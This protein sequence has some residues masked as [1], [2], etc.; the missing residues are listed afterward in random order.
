MFLC[1]ASAQKDSNENIDLT[2]SMFQNQLQEPVRVKKFEIELVSSI[3]RKEN[4]IT[5][6]EPDNLLLFRLGPIDAGE[7]YT[8]ELQSGVYTLADLAI[9]IARALN[10]AT[11]CNAWRGWSCSVDGTN[12]FTITFTTVSTPGLDTIAEITEVRLLHNGFENNYKFDI[13]NDSISLEAKY[14]TIGEGNE[15][16][17]TTENL[18]DLLGSN[19]DNLSF[20]SFAGLDTGFENPE[21]YTNTAIKEVGL[22]EAGGRVEYILSPVPVFQTSGVYGPSTVA[23]DVYLT[24]ESDVDGTQYDP[25]VFEESF[26]KDVMMF[27]YTSTAGVVSKHSQKNGILINPAPNANANLTGPPYTRGKFTINFPPSDVA[28]VFDDRRQELYKNTFGGN[29]IFDKNTTTQPIDARAF[30]IEIGGSPAEVAKSTLHFQDELEAEKLKFRLST[31]PLVIGLQVKDDETLNSSNILQDGPLPEVKGTSISYIPGTIGRMN[32]RSFGLPAFV[33]SKQGELIDLGTGETHYKTP[34]YRIEAVD[35]NGIPT[36]VV[37][38]DGGEHI[39]LTAD[40]AGGELFLNDPATF[41]TSGGTATNEEVVTNLCSFLDIGDSKMLGNQGLIEEVQTAFQYLPTEVGIVNDQVFQAIQNGINDNY[42]NSVPFPVQYSKDV[43]VKVVPLTRTNDSHV[44]FSV[45]QFQPEE[46]TFG[47]EGSISSTFRNSGDE[48]DFK[49]LLVKGRPKTWNSLSYTSGSAPT[50]WTAAFAAPDKDQRIKIS[51][52]QKQIYQQVI[53]CSFSTDAGA[54]F[55]EE[56]TLL[57]TSNKIA[58]NKKFEFTTKPRLFP[59]HPCISQYP[60]LLNNV[61]PE[62]ETTEIKG[63]FTTYPRSASYRQGERV[64]MGTDGNYAKN[65]VFQTADATQPSIFT[66][67]TSLGNNHRPQIVLKTK[68]TG[69]TEVS[70]ASAY[71]LSDGEIRQQEVPPIRATLGAV[72][73]L[74]SAYSAEE[75]FTSPKNFVGA[76]STSVLANIPTV[77]VEIN[78]I[79]IDGYIAKDFDVRDSQTGV[80]SRLPIVGVIPSLEDETVS[81]KPKIDFRYNAPYSQPVRCNLPTEQ[82]LYNLSFR[83]REI[84]TGRIVEGLR[85]P[86]ELIFR[87]NPLEENEEKENNM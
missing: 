65:L 50:N 67:P 24:L 54:S 15:A 84:A 80:G 40:P 16:I 6:T 4:K 79:P 49:Q 74:H 26:V 12:K 43:S 14:D 66:F 19:N 1:V 35:I 76:S 72:I 53:K 86:T 2:A 59:M 58:G 29:M 39:A 87:I 51:I 81:T 31:S 7:A 17:E 61:V 8:A 71:P 27:N 77:A 78:N 32:E 10:D 52:E 57:E 68:K 11:P 62:N 42:G 22:F 13:L 18:Q 5:I 30:R 33:A 55:Q 25:S 3:I 75:E 69:F 20:A 21:T 48:R 70:N 9:E 41:V 28:D 56:I 23:D 46:T 37:L 45:F 73:G 60:P 63:I 34:V 83:L 82:F 64:I 36:D 44:E 38:I 85:H 47:D